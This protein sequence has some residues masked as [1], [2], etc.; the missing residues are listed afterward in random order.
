[1]SLN[2]VV[3]R[4]HVPNIYLSSTDH[5]LTNYWNPR[6]REVIPRELAHQPDVNIITPS[7][8]DD[9]DWFIY[10]VILNEPF[11]FVREF[12]F[13]DH[14]YGFWRR[15]NP[16]VKNRIDQGKGIVYVAMNSEPVDK[17]DLQALV[18]SFVASGEKRIVFNIHHS[19]YEKEGFMSYPGWMEDY[20]FT[21]LKLKHFVDTRGDSKLIKSP[22]QKKYLL[23]NERYEKHAGAVLITSLLDQHNLFKDGYAYVDNPDSISEFFENTKIQMMPETKLQEHSVPVLENVDDLLKGPLV[24]SQVMKHTF[25]NLVVEAYYSDYMINYPFVTE[26]I[27]RNLVY[28]KPFICVGQKDTLKQLHHWGYKTFHPWIDE[29]YDNL[30]DDNRIFAIFDQVKKLCSMSDTE[31]TSMCNELEHIHDHNIKNFHRRCEDFGT[32]L[33]QLKTR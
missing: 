31:L 17:F 3:D 32:Y 29:Q 13:L 20:E 10:P 28:R 4:H 18:D 26:K 7:E 21:T 11:F 6:T 24:F 19:N 33:R 2:I 15:V 22:T 23:A 25:F 27:W 14:P 8:L 9:V 12:M 5:F 16:E 1:M 30:D